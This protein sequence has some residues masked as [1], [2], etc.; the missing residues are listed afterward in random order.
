MS[1]A[2][3]IID[4]KNKKRNKRIQS[5]LLSRQK[6]IDNYLNQFAGQGERGGGDN[7]DGLKGSN[8]IFVGI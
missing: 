2:E 7:A 8:L 1:Q 3:K 6:I 5:I 4:L